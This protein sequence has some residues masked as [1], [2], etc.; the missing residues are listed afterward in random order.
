MEFDSIK[1]PR[2]A[3][4]LGWVLMTEQVSDLTLLCST[5]GA[6]SQSMSMDKLRM[7][8]AAISFPVTCCLYLILYRFRQ[9]RILSI[10]SVESMGLCLAFSFILPSH[11]HRVECTVSHQS[12][13]IFH[14]KPGHNSRLVNVPTG[15]V[16]CI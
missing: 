7:V 1:H 5:E 14:L 9:S 10:F 2:K 16:G 3:S 13:G 11:G 6:E 4:G 12:C 8:T 15:T